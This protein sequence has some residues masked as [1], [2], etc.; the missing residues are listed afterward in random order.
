MGGLCLR[1][2][3]PKLRKLYL[4][5]NKVVIVDPLLDLR[6]LETL[7]LFR[8]TVLDLRRCISVLQQVRNR[9][10]GSSLPAHC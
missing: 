1:W 4:S 3:C 2:Q 6:C 8:N 10:T 9:T 5:N 7:C